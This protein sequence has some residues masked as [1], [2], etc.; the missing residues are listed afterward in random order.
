MRSRSIAD[1]AV[2]VADNHEVEGVTFGKLA[3]E[4]L[5]LGR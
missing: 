1:D 4:Q 5:D 3:D 2:E